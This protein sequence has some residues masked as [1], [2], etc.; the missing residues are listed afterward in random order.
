MKKQLLG[1]ARRREV[2]AAVVI[3]AFILSY[4][5]IASQRSNEYS[6]DGLKII[7]QEPPRQA[8]AKFL[9][10]NGFLIEERLY[11]TTADDRN[12]AVQ[13]IA[14]EV[15]YALAAHGKKVNAYGTFEGVPAINC[16][17]NTSNCRGANVIVGISE[18][19]C[20]RIGDRLEIFGNSQFLKDSVVKVRGV[21]GL[22]L[23][24]VAPTPSVVPTP[25]ANNSSVTVPESPLPPQLRCTADANCSRGGPYGIVCGITEL[26]QT[27][28]TSAD[29][30]PEFGCFESNRSLTSCACIEGKCAWNRTK[31]FCACG[32]KYGKTFKGC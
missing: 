21:L 14:A 10:G 29:W 5:F 30:K 16:N 13:M 1:T 28:N 25:A 31:E 32:W 20:M 2:I 18:C 27:V 7:S 8:L 12:V 3:A 22:V 4:Y 26:V 9:S 17:S 6:L 11:N 19:N 24:D 23:N 15:S